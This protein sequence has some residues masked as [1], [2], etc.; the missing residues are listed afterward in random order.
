LA[1]KNAA[2]DEDETEYARVRDTKLMSDVDFGVQGLIGGLASNP[3]VPAGSIGSV[4]G[5]SESCVAGAAHDL[6]WRL[7][8]SDGEESPKDLRKQNAK[9]ALFIPIHGLVD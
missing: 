7:S 9:N 6:I 4:D 2:K 8:G 5:I 1:G 3:T